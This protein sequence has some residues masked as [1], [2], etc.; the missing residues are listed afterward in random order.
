MK[1]SGLRPALK[2]QAGLFLAL[3]IMFCTVSLAV[4]ADDDNH[5][6]DHS[7]ARMQGEEFLS[8]ISWTPHFDS[9]N[10]QSANQ[11]SAMRNPPSVRGSGIYG[12]LPGLSPTRGMVFSRA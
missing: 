9:E 11:Q 3:I 10:Q 2:K 7:K 12:S 5:G 4:F 8:A 6:I 1:F